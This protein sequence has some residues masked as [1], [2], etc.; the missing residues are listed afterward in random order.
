[1][2][3]Y[4]ELEQLV[5]HTHTHTSYKELERLVTSRLAFA[6]TF[7]STAFPAINLPW[8]GGS[9]YAKAALHKCKGSTTGAGAIRLSDLQHLPLPD[10]LFRATPIPPEDARNTW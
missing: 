4:K 6:S 5:T 10:V 7:A 9:I 1:M 3:S 2:G 8:L